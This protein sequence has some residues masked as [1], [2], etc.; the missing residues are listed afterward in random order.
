MSATAHVTF[1]GG[2]IALPARKPYDRDLLVEQVARRAARAALA[3][4]SRITDD[5]LLDQLVAFGISADTLTALSLVPLVEVAW[6]DG[7]VEDAERQAILAAARAAGLQEESAGH[8]LLDSCLSER[9]RTGL[10]K[11]WKQYITSI[12]TTLPAEQRDALKTE[13]LQQGRRVAEAAGGFMGLGSRVSSKEEALLAEIAAA[14]Q[15][16]AEPLRS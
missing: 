7:R 10:R 8:K 15:G 4:A 11:M 14:F 13:L 1:A 5:V 3:A 12:C 2:G 16:A 6:A 9:P